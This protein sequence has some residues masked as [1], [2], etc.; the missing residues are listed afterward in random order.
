MEASRCLKNSKKNFQEQLQSQ[1]DLL[2][3]KWQARRSKSICGRCSCRRPT[4]LLRRDLHQSSFWSARGASDFSVVV[5][6]GA[7]KLNTRWHNDRATALFASRLIWGTGRLSGRGR[8]TSN[9]RLS[10]RPFVLASPFASPFCLCSS[11]PWTFIGSRRFSFSNRRCHCFFSFKVLFL[12]HATL[13]LSRFSCRG[14]AARWRTF[15]QHRRARRC[16]LH[17][18]STNSFGSTWCFFLELHSKGQR[19]RKGK[20]NIHSFLIRECK[21]L[22]Q[23]IIRLQFENSCENRQDPSGGGLLLIVLNLRNQTSKTQ[24]SLYKQNRAASLTLLQQRGAR[25]ELAH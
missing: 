24:Q 19:R 20:P 13:W 9:S 18:R 23:I 15:L 11:L 21:G 3:N 4:P 17:H 5:A 16:T 7:T 12:T 1:E 2:T 8:F 10:C 6:F 22:E 25:P 14:M